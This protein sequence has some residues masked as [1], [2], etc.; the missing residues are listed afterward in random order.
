MRALLQLD[1]H[2]LYLMHQLVNLLF[3]AVNHMQYISLIA[4]TV[5]AATLILHTAKIGSNAQQKIIQFPSS[6]K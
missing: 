3:L 6:N 2:G 4:G 5:A 1:L